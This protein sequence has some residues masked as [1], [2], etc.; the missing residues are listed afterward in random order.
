[1][2]SGII[3]LN[4][5]LLKLSEIFQGYCKLRRDTGVKGVKTNYRI[6]SS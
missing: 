3:N 6:F 4:K 1:M 5:T 2:F